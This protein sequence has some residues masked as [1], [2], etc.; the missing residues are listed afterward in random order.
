MY[1][2][3]TDFSKSITFKEV[4]SIVV[5]PIVSEAT[6]PKTK[7]WFHTP[8]ACCCLGQNYLTSLC[9]SF[10]IYKNW[11]IIVPSSVARKKI[12]PVPGLIIRK[13]VVGLAFIIIIKIIFT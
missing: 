5:K 12:K 4:M 3:Q 2:S 11:I 10:P 6:F 13:T 8:Y 1:I 9:F 7:F